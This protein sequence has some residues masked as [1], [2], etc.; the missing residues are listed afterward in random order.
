MTE[1]A[2]FSHLTGEYP[3]E[4]ARVELLSGVIAQH[5]ALYPGVPICDLRPL[6][7][8]PKLPASQATDGVR[9]YS[10]VARTQAAENNPGSLVDHVFVVADIFEGGRPHYRQGFELGHLMALMDW[11]REVQDNY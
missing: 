10:V 11:H 6:I 4:T 3:L 2:S 5:R 1:V 9:R 7:Y 8:D